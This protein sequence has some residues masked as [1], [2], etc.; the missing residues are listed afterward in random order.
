MEI[1]LDNCA[2]TRVCEEATA[3]CL[4]AMTGSYGN[5]SSLHRKG[6]EAEAILTETRKTVGRMLSC[7]PGMH[8]LHR[9]CH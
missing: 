8:T 5:P 9:Q 4:Q 1:Y 3:A 2:T 6:L 7:P